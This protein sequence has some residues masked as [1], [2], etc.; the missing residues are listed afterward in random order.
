[1]KWKLVGL[2]PQ[3][4]M[5]VRTAKEETVVLRG[6]I[7]KATVVSMPKNLFYGGDVEAVIE[8]VRKVA[9][10]LTGID[11]VLIVQ[12]GVEFFRLV[13]EGLDELINE[14]MGECE[15]CCLDNEQDRT[16]LRETLMNLLTRL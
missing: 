13:P 12:E 15:S 4:G 14:A 16:R 1:M 6:S 5:E 8:R 2:V 9:Q 11:D 7:G 10:E 3:D